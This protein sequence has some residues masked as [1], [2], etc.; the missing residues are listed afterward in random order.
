MHTSSLFLSFLG[1]KEVGSLLCH[2]TLCV[3]CG[4]TFQQLN[5]LADFCENWYEHSTIGGHS[6]AVIFLL[7]TTNGN[8]VMNMQTCNSGASK[9]H[10]LFTYFLTYS[11]EQSLFPAL[12]GTQRF[13]TAFTRACYPSL[14]WARSIYS[15]PSY[16]TPWRS[17]F[18]LYSHLC[19]CLSSGLFPSGFLTK[20]LYT[21]LFS[22][23]CATCSAY[24]IL[25]N[26]IIQIIYG[27]EYG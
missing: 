25:L 20:T 14:S 6:M 23:I 4:A 12:Y 8:N 27:E 1:G 13:I 18:I 5:H 24:F 2:H 3:M 16:P 26:S 22:S 7:P 9:Q 10:I 11:L 17:I 15:T 21:P 19:L